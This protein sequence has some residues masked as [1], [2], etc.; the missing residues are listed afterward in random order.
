MSKYVIKGMYWAAGNDIFI[1]MQN[2]NEEWVVVRLNDFIKNNIEENTRIS[3][4]IDVEE[5]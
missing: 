3:I 2:E 4:V 5:K 1:D